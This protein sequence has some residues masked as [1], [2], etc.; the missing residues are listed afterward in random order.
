[1]IMMLIT[2]TPSHV[3]TWEEEMKQCV[4]IL[5][6]EPGVWGALTDVNYFYYSFVPGSTE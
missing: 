6:P 2:I 1:M 3:G 4:S 5:Y